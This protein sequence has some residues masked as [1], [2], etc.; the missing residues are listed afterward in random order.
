MSTRFSRRWKTK[1]VAR[2]N[3]GDVR[4]PSSCGRDNLEQKPSDDPKRLI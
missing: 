1:S 2:M 4:R 3:Q